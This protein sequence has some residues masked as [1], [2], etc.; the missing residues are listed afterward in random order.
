[1]TKDSSPCN[2]TLIYLL[3][4]RDRLHLKQEEKA[5]ARLQRRCQREQEGRRSERTEVREA[6]LDRRSVH[7][8]ESAMFSGSI[9]VELDSEGSIMS[10]CTDIS[11]IIFM[12]QLAQAHPHNV[13]HFLVIIILYKLQIMNK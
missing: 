8:E 2:S 5:S 12:Y 3:S 6:R 11:D 4:A 10:G 13:L 9:G 7:G 1:M